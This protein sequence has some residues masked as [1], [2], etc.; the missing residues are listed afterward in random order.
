MGRSQRLAALPAALLLGGCT[1]IGS[2]GR[3]A[4]SVS[5]R[6]PAGG[7]VASIPDI[8]PSP[9][10]PAGSGNMVSYEQNGHRYRVL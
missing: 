4:P 1:M 6:P 7:S 5:S 2:Q 10:P 9:E 3:M 8:I